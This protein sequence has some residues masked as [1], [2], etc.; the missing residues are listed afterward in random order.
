MCLHRSVSLLMI[1]CL[2]YREIRSP[3]DCNLMQ[4]DLDTLVKWSKTWGMM[5]NIKKC[6]IISITNGTKKTRSTTSTPWPRPD[7]E[8]PNSIDTCVYLGI[9]VNSRLRWNQHI[10][11]T[12][13]AANRM[14]CFF[15][16]TL[17]RCPQHLKEKTGCIMYR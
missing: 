10:D 1:G 15:R 5:F 8:P 3:S 14:L 9:T 13:A 11:Q 12:S 6:N 2:I 17:Y 16:R 7:N 4:N